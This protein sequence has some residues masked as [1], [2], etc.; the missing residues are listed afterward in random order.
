M[1][2]PLLRVKGLRTEIPGGPGS[3][4]AVDDLSFDIHQGE[5]LGIVGE[6]GS[7]KS[8]TALSIMGLVAPAGRVTAK[9]MEFDGWDLTGL[10]EAAM[11]RLRGREMAMIFQDPMTSLNP[12]LSI[13]FQ[14]IEQLRWR[15]GLSRRQARRQAVELLGRVGISGAER[16]LDD[17]PHQ[18]SGGMRQRVS[19]AMAIS[20]EPKLLIADEATTALDVTI[21]AQITDLIMRLCEESG[22]SVMWISHDLGVVAGLCDRVNVMYAGRLAESADAMSLYAHSRHGYTRGLMKS[23]PRIDRRRQRLEA[24]AGRPPSLIDLPKTCPFE[25]RCAYSTPECGAKPA[26]RRNFGENHIAYCWADLP[27]EEGVE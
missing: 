27:A 21:Q 12:V 7:G 3:V 6:S 18:F 19:I 24:I 11:R 1:S 14:L 10:D 25:P 8:M 13:G 20:C 9:R 26:P 4:V 16:R 17:Y 5:I 23:V 15:L 22:M 2:E